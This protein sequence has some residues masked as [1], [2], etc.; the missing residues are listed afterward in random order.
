[1]NNPVLPLV[2]P[3]YAYVI[4][5]MVFITSSPHPWA[6]ILKRPFS[7]YT[8][9]LFVND[10]NSKVRDVAISSNQKLIY[11][12]CKL[13]SFWLKYF[14]AQ[15]FFFHSCTLLGCILSPM[16]WLTLLGSN[17]ALLFPL[18][19]AVAIFPNADYGVCLCFYIVS[20]RCCV[21]RVALKCS[22]VPLLVSLFFIVF[23]CHSYVR[24]LRS[25]VHLPSSN[26]MFHITLGF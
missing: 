19:F 2:D 17:C 18:H 25:Y 13:V 7:L 12:K 14:S 15:K 9:C 8:I 4:L 16:F 22:S 1:M 23:R 3:L 24:S 20:H 10:C 26:L 11:K 5:M 6:K 21:Y